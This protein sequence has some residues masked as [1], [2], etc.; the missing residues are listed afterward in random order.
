MTKVMMLYDN[1]VVCGFHMEGHARFNLGGPDVI[2]ASLSAA[3]Q[4][5]INGL[6]DWIGCDY[7][8]IVKLNDVVQG[9]LR[10]E[11]PK[12]MYANATAQQLFKAFEIYIK[13]L[14]EQYPENVK[15]IE[16][17]EEEE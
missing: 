12:P 3:S 17:S 9:L 8:D 11:L 5:T 2:C 10:I 1:N 4:L 14:S 16:R 15:L 13:L 7:E 6:L